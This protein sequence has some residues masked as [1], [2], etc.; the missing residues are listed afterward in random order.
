MRRQSLSTLLFMLVFGAFAVGTFAQEKAN[1]P[2]VG[3]WVCDDDG[4]QV[5]I[6]ANGSLTINNEEYAYRVKGSVI[7]VIGEDGAMAIPFQLDGDTLT[8]DVEGREMVYVR[9][10]AG[11]KVNKDG[12]TAAGG[13]MQALVGKWCYMSNLTG[14][15]SRMSNRCFVLDASGTYE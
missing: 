15:N 1:N 5:Q 13:V 12:G 4:T 14:S 6:R 8:V 7:N 11:G 3:N 10:K 2:L 9:A